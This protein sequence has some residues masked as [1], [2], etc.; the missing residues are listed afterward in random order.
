MIKPRKRFGQNF[1][2]DQGL[3]GKIIRSFD[4]RPGEQVVE[5]GPGQ[6]ALTEHLVNTGCDL[7]LVEIDRDLADLLAE[8]FP[9]VN[10]MNEDVLKADLPA[11][12]SE[13]PVRVIGNL[14][15][16]ISTP[17]MFRLFKHLELFHDMHF[18]LQ[19][20]V[21]NR[22]TAEP[23]TKN[24]GRLSIM[25]QLYCQAEKLFEVPPEAFN[26]RP[27]VQSA[28]VRL[29]P[30]HRIAQVDTGVIEP[31]LI[32]AFSSRRKTIRNALKGLISES[33]LESLGLSP[34]LRPENL[35]VEDYI[36]CSNLISARS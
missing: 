17:L 32:Q 7:T 18:M 11:V 24:Y 2:V 8:R 30:R 29:E 15:Y 23:S 22:M 28:I 20:E 27:K 16:N 19:L 14:P 26:P 1:L 21:V 13:P 31:M 10:L 36:A 25:T 6:G 3:I 35:S 9:N 33:E 12:I 5:I 34:T 4:T